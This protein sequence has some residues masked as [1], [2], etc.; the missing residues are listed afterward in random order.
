MFG[1]QVLKKEC[2]ILKL[3]QNK[4]IIRQG[5]MQ[6]KVEQ[7][8]QPHMCFEILAER[9]RQI[10]RQHSMGVTN[11]ILCKKNIYQC[12]HNAEFYTKLCIAIWLPKLI[13]TP[14]GAHVSMF[15]CLLYPII[16]P[17]AGSSLWQILKTALIIFTLRRNYCCLNW[18]GWKSWT[19]L[20]VLYT[21]IFCTK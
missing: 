3:C 15:D 9:N 11:E 1:T 16:T 7:I 19:N 6:V 2:G 4:T 10:F 14:I 5:T 12:C 21:I 20:I 13:K 17:K 8:Y 18:N